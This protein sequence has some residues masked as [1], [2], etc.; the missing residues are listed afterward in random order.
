M[1]VVPERRFDRSLL[2]MLILNCEKRRLCDEIFL[3]KVQQ[4]YCERR[5][6][7][8]FFGV[9]NGPKSV[10]APRGNVLRFVGEYEGGALNLR[11]CDFAEAEVSAVGRDAKAKPF[12]KDK[13]V[14]EPRGGVGGG[15]DAHVV[16]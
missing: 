9:R 13:V 14:D 3:A 10:C 12:V 1:G 11:R 7:F 5:A 8:S 16:R 6:F 4:S 2:Q 15:F